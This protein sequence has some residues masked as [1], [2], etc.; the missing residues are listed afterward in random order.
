MN[1]PMK[2]TAADRAVSDRAFAVTANELRSF[3]ERLEQ[4]DAEKRDAADRQKEVAAK[5]KSRGYCPKTLRKIVALRKREPDDVAEEQAIL[6]LYR[7]VLGL[8]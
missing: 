5:A 4:L 3:V 8:L 1:A 2:N 7:S 6:D